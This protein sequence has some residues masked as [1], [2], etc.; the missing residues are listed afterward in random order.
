MLAKNKIDPSFFALDHRN[1]DLNSTKHTKVSSQQTCSKFSGFTSNKLH[2]AYRV[3]NKVVIKLEFTSL[4][5]FLYS[6]TSQIAHKAPTKNIRIQSNTKNYN[7]YIE[8]SKTGVKKN[9]NFRME[10]RQPHSN[11]CKSPNRN[12]VTFLEE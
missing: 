6:F 11:T 8:L 5:H 12:R 2:K 4:M 7:Y 1:Y 9:K 10:Q 3:S